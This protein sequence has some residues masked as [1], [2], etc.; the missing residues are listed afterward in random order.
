MFNNQIHITDDGS[1]TFFNAQV[2]EHY[3]STFGAIQESQHIFIEAG[4]Y[5]FLYQK[6]VSVLEVGF[7]TGLN[8]L[9]ALIVA[10]KRGINVHYSAIELYPINLTEAARLNF[11]E[12]LK[13]SPEL[14]LTMHESPVM[15]AYVTDYFH[16][17]KW[18]ESFEG[19]ALEAQSY[20]VVFFDAFSPEVQP[21]MWTTKGFSK[22]FTA[23]KPG[24]YLVTYSCKG[25]VKRA[26]KEAGFVLEKLPGPPGKREFLRAGRPE[27]S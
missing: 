22:L 8:A 19:I 4:L 10:Q 12:L 3:H 18:Q 9:L 24:G 11:P 17:R 20:D 5:P 16:L 2:G 14:F 13:V 15:D 21:E 1:A 26:L 25:L 27:W 7:G 23:L 6:S